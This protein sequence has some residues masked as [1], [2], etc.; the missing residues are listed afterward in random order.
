ME[1]YIKTPTILDYEDTRKKRFVKNETLQIGGAFK[2]RGVYNKLLNEGCMDKY[3]GII[4]ASTGNHGIAV[5]IAASKSDIKCIVVVPRNTSKIKKDRIAQY[6]AEV[7]D[8]MFDTYDECMNYCMKREVNEEYLYISS[9]DD[10]QMIEGHKSMFCECSDEYGGMFFD[11]CICAVGGGGLVGAAQSYKGK[12]F[13]R[14]IGVEI[15]KYDAMRQSLEKGERIKISLEGSQHSL[16]ESLLI[17]KVGELPYSIAK[18][19]ELDVVTV[20]ENE[21]KKAIFMLSKNG[22]VAEGAGAITVA[23]AMRDEY[24]GNIL[25]VVSGGNI[26]QDEYE[27]IK[28]GEA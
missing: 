13:K 3:K 26:N 21:V 6:G 14:L 1:K 19:N 8:D 11:T 18:Q 17:S 10:L 2:Y 23:T 9:F 15:E 25:C 28:R 4:T 12:L 16:C 7:I 24:M 27:R 22:I 5:S 20:S